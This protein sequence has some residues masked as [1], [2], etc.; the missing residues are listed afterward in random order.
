VRR[1]FLLVV[2]L[3]LPVAAAPRLKDRK[4]APDPEEARIA[5][6]KARYAEVRASG[7]KGENQK[8]DLAHVKLQIHWLVLDDLA[9]QPIT[10]EA[11]R[12]RE[13][14]LEREIRSDPMLGDL[15]D[16][17][18]YDRKKAADGK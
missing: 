3:T 8:L 18:V 15:Y 6:L 9:R 17:A 5:A 13:C 7:Q 1:A 11:R 14:E 16:I 2:L 10:P 4:P 12:Q